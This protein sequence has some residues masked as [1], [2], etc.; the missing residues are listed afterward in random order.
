MDAFMIKFAIQEEIK[1]A[2][3]SLYYFDDDPLP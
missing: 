2:I 1:S 3:F